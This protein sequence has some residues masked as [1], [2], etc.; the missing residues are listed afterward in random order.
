MDGVYS[1]FLLPRQIFYDLEC[2]FVIVLVQVVFYFAALLS[3]PIFFGIFHAFSDFFV[4]F[5]IFISS[6]GTVL[7][8]FQYINV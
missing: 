7:S 1:S 4:D 5:P 2:S 8:I 3:Y 6:Y